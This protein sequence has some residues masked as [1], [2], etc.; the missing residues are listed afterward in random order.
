[1]GSIL[2]FFGEVFPFTRGDVRF[3]RHLSNTHYVLLKGTIRVQRRLQRMIH[4]MLLKGHLPTLNRGRVN[5]T[6]VFDKCLFSR[7]PFILRLFCN[8][9]RAKTKRIRYVTRVESLQ[10]ST[11]NLRFLGGVRALSVEK[12]RALQRNERRLP[13]PLYR[14]TNVRRLLSRFSNRGRV[15]LRAV[16]RNGWR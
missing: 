3:F 10:L 7:V 12:Y 11:A 14:V 15:P 1:M 4:V 16:V 13:Y 9:N 6:T 2:S 5:R 8:A